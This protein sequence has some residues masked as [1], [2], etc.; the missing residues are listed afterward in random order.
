[1]IITGAATA[2]TWVTPTGVEGTL[3]LA[4]GVLGGVGQYL[5]FEGCRLA[6]ASVMA[7]VEYTRPDLGLRT[8]LSGLGRCPVGGDLHRRRADSGGAGLV[9]AYFGAAGQARLSRIRSKAS[10]LF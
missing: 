5:L 8:R 7:T 2:L 9:F 1:M 6:P 10:L 3:L 4:I